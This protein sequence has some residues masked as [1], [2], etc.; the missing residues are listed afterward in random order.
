MPELKPGTGVVSFETGGD[1]FK[2]DIENMKPSVDVTNQ[3][4]TTFLA[5]PPVQQVSSKKKL[6]FAQTS[7]SAN[8]GKLY[9]I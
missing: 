2:Q 4:S 9:F 5:P 3:L 7:A 8:V 6:N 1:R